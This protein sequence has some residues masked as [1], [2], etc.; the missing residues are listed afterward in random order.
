M[1]FTSY[2]LH[3]RV[4]FITTK[5]LSYIRNT[6]ELRICREYAA[7]VDVLGSESSC[8]PVRLMKVYGSLLLKSCRKYDVIFLGFSPQLILPVWFWKFRKQFIMIDFF[9]SMYDTLCLDRG[10]VKPDGSLGKWLKWIDKRTLA[11]ADWSLCD[12]RAHGRFFQRELGAREGA[13]EV[14]YLEADQDL[15]D[16]KVVSKPEEWKNCFVVL[17]FGS[18]LPL[19]GVDVILDAIEGVQSQEQSV[20]RLRFVLVGPLSKQQAKRIDKLSYVH[21][22][23]WLS[24]QALSDCI[25]MADLCL[26]GHFHPT[27]EKAHRTIPG[28]AYIYE[29]MEKPMIL[30]E[31]AANRERYQEGEGISFVPMGD[32]RALLQEILKQYEKWSKTEKEILPGN[33]DKVENEKQ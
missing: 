12:T 18:I 30:G 6:Q 29:T 14:L 27:I 19:Q 3:N 8:Y 24:Q 23:K 11:L 16:P 32:A 4:L 13:M 33:E 31:N 17:Y 2:L 20:G 28:K 26:A 9:L 7:Q 25:A 15:Y 1:E 5:Q 22:E 21:W 10:R